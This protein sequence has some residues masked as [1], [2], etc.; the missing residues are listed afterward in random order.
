MQCRRE[1]IRESCVRCGRQLADAGGVDR[2]RD[3]RSR[4]ERDASSTRTRFA[5]IV[6]NNATPIEPPICRKS[7]EPLVATPIIDGS[8]E[9]GPSARAPA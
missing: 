4:G 7:V 1:R 2:L 8:T 6:P 5:K 3:V 9:F